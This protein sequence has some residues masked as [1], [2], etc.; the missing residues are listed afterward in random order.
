MESTARKMWQKAAN[1]GSV[2]AAELIAD[3]M[4]GKPLQATADV[5][6]AVSRAERVA[7]ILDDLDTRREEENNKPVN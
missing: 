2:R 5:T 4:E 1:E 6:D 7:Q 3:R